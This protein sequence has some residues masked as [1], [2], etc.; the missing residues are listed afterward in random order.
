MTQA[1]VAL[2]AAILVPLARL[3]S[4]E[5]IH[6][7][8]SSGAPLLWLLGQSVWS[9]FWP[10][11]LAA[12]LA[13]YYKS[14][15]TIALSKNLRRLAIGTA[16]VLGGLFTVLP[17]GV[18]LVFALMGSM[19]SH[20]PA[21]GLWLL[22][23]ASELALALFLLALA[24]PAAQGDGDRNGGSGLLRNAAV[25]AASMGVIAAIVSVTNGVTNAQLLTA[26]A[27]RQAPYWEGPTQFQAVLS[28]V[29]S[30]MPEFCR[31]LIPLIVLKA[32][33]PGQSVSHAPVLPDNGDAG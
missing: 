27:H 1:K 29:M 30:V 17:Y 26:T 3:H 23:P 21:P 32:L 12:M 13:V 18:T 25:F 33:A 5:W 28:S 22:F 31:L 20:L 14:G 2:L 6:T 11:A 8:A 10:L 16:V 9:L 15:A 19:A 7:L 24:G 4:I